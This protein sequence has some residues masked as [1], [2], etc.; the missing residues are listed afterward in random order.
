MKSFSVLTSVYYKEKPEYLK[1]AL[2]SIFSQ[3]LLPNE[4]VLVKDGPLGDELEAVIDESIKKHAETSFVVVELGQN[5]G[6]GEALNKGL[7][8]VSSEYVM[9]VDTDDISLPN[10]FDRQMRFLDAHPEVSILGSNID[11]Y[12]ED[13][14]RKL[15]V[16]EVPQSHDEIVN[17]MKGRNAFNHMAVVFKKS[18]I[19]RV[20]QYQPCP[21]FEDYYLWLRVLSAGGKF[22]NIQESLVRARAGS[23]MISRRGGFS[24]ISNIIAFYIKVRRLK[25]MP[26]SQI[27]KSCLGR[28]AV[29]IMPN[30]LR[31]SIY[32]RRLR[33]R[34]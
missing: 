23:S 26:D 22:H 7:E 24:Y 31:A 32:R 15:S 25:I 3:S 28:S 12:D 6:L 14:L 19:I 4:V 2:D 11:E 10:R 8:R 27:L 17:F 16:R 9:R 34:F 5:V 18:A 30:S 20:G 21:F 33:S 29:A 13:M 1:A